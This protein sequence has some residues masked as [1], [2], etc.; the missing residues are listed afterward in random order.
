LIYIYSFILNYTANIALFA[1]GDKTDSQENVPECAVAISE[2]EIKVMV[3]RFSRG[4]ETNF[5]LLKKASQKRR[6]SFQ[7]IPFQQ[8][9][10]KFINKRNYPGSRAAASKKGP[11]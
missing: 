1:T 2:M 10:P 6:K 11:N 8:T 9:K 7:R 5:S 3:L 4:I